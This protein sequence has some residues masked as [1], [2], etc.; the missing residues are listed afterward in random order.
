MSN[1]STNGIHEMQSV[2]CFNECQLFQRMS[3]ISTNGIN[4]MQFLMF[5]AQQGNYWYHLYNVFGMT[6]SLLEASTL[7]LGY[8]GGGITADLSNIFSDVFS[9][10]STLY[11][12]THSS[13]CTLPVGTTIVSF[14]GG[15]SLRSGILPPAHSGL[16]HLAILQYPKTS[17]QVI[18]VLCAIMAPVVRSY[19][20]NPIF[21]T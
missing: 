10:F 8:R 14:C 2:K 1:I 3:I 5:S 13:R 16:D 20:G 6:R 9:H 18:S 15:V 11:L 17:V 21:I 7:P 12:R 19:V 4:E